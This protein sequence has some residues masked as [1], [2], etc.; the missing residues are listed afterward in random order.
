MAFYGGR[1]IIS[2]DPRTLPADGWCVKRPGHPDFFCSWCGAPVLMS[3][4]NPGLPIT[5]CPV[6]DAPPMDGV[7]RVVDIEKEC[8]GDA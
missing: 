8:N 1:R 2:R 3:V 7:L 5:V 4:R 6:C